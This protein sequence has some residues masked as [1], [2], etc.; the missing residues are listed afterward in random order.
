M[1]SVP[2]NYIFTLAAIRGEIT[3]LSYG[4]MDGL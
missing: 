4:K 3:G 2:W 1:E